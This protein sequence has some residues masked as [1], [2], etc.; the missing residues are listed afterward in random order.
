MSGKVIS[1]VTKKG[2]PEERD[3]ADSTLFQNK[4][5]SLKKGMWQI[6]PISELLLFSYERDKTEK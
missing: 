1:S 2:F 4:R 6:A 5:G 3:V